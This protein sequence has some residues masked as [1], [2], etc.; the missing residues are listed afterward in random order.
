MQHPGRHLDLCT[1]ARA[2]GFL[3]SAG[4]HAAL[5][6]LLLWCGGQHDGAQG[7]DVPFA[8]LVSVEA[9]EAAHAE[10]SGRFPIEPT[11]PIPRIHEA[12]P[13]LTQ[14][15]ALGE[16]PQS[17]EQAPANAAQQDDA[18]LSQPEVAP[19]PDI[20]A[21][22]TI[23]AP[24]Q[25]ALIVYLARLAERLPADTS[26]PARFR[27]TRNDGQYDAIL[28]YERASNGM[29]FDRVVADVGTIH[30]GQH[31][32]TR[33]TLRR[34]PFSQ[35]AHVVD[36]WD[37]MVQ[38]HDDEIVGR[39]HS[40]TPFNLELDAHTAPRFL[41]KVTTAAGTFHAR[42]RGSRRE[43]DI[44]LGGIET[45]AGRIRLPDKLHPLESSPPDPH[46]RTHEL[47]TDTHIRFFADGSYSW[48]ARGDARPRHMTAP[49]D[50]PVYFI[51]APGVTLY[52]RG[53]VAG[54][55]LVYSP[56][57]IV[58]EG[59]LLYA[60]DPR[61]EPSPDYLGLVSDKFIEIAPPHM[62]GPGDL[63]IQ[64]AIFARRRFIITHVHHRRAGTL[65]VY[66]SL[67]AGSISASEP[68]Y[69]TRIE[70]DHR[71]EQ[72]RPPSFPATN[73]F[74][75]EQW[76]GTWTEVSERTASEGL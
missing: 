43:S 49:T 45:R 39:V 72:H 47:S 56:Y 1:A 29:D 30:R 74:E 54:Q 20:P 35:F 51:A 65:R 26:A 33:I 40:N 42:G 37:P 61:A 69:A 18:V 27:W 21:T 71:F 3:M 16:S 38:F 67:S 14:A 10:G 75:I 66:G 48:Q 55:V 36:R 57:K 34:L 13:T 7:T 17:N 64:A 76:D 59:P 41:G 9:P 46:V 68:R 60:R 44:F 28:R 52:V 2:S 15:N 25:A 31:L 24:E 50:Q 4:L 12:P 73:R 62:T 8:K 5:F 53:V 6:V 70:Y 32:R 11:W 22:I 19:P 63:E 58:I 23:P